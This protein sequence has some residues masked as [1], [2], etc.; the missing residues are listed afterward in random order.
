MIQ[1]SNP[2]GKE[3]KGS[4]EKF[5]KV[6]YSTKVQSVVSSSGIMNAIDKE[7]A[8]ILNNKGFGPQEVQKAIVNLLKQYA[9][10]EAVI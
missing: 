2:G 4:F 10:N 1:N 5:F 9:K 8:L 6:W 7:T 3:V